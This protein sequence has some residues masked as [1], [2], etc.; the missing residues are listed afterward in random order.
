MADAETSSGREPV[1]W[2]ARACLNG[3]I[4]G[5]VCC[6]AP[7]AV[8]L[9]ATAETAVRWALAS[10]PWRIPASAARCSRPGAP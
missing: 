1:R 2:L 6:P 10:G 4:G 3:A 7:M 5:L 8:A 9:L